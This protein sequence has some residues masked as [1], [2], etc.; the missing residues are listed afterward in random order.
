MPSRSAALSACTI[1]VNSPRFIRS[2]T[3]PTAPD[4]VTRPRLGADEDIR[5]RVQQR[6]MASKATAR[7]TTRRVAAAAGLRSRAAAPSLSLWLSTSPS[8]RRRQL[9]VLY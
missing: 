3:V 2:P 6:H 9:I 4:S 8:R 1:S 7:A 5:A